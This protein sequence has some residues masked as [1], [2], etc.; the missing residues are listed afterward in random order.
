[1]VTNLIRFTILFICSSII[2][3]EE[4]IYS[5]LVVILKERSSLRVLYA[6]T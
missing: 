5:L 2:S 4:I 6:A 3:I 1:V